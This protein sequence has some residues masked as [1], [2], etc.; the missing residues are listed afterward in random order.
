MRQ[1]VYILFF[2]CVAMLL[3]SAATAQDFNIFAKQKVVVAD[4]VDNNER[5]LSDGIKLVIRQSI[6]DAFVNSDS[7]E[8]FDVNMD[9]IKQQLV[10]SGKAIDFMNICKRIGQQA[11]YIIFASVKTTSSD[12]RAQDVK[13]IINASLY[14]IAT[15]SEVLSDVVIATAN[16]ESIMFTTSQ[17]VAKL[18]G[19]EPTNSKTQA[20]EISAPTN[21][22]QNQITTSQRIAEQPKTTEKSS[23]EQNSTTDLTE[24][25]NKAVFLMKEKKDFTTAIKLFEDIVNEG[26]TSNDTLIQGYVASAKNFVVNCY[27][28]LANRY[29]FKDMNM[30]NAYILKA[31]EKSE[32]YGIKISR[33]YYPKSGAF[34]MK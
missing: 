7:Y 16:S 21:R 1:G 34:Q 25:Y 24:K 26:A 5:Q 23:Q 27:L 15:A 32:Q 22:S 18:L 17:L 3:S 10:N 20:Q 11:D 2:L 4:I 33:M 29:A 19:V 14:R 31:I 30:S 6:V 12:P 9:E 13:L 28:R 8:V